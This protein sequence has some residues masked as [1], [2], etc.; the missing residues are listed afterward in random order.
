ML[1]N[2]CW[3][4][5]NL[6]SPDHKSHVAYPAAGPQTFTGSS[7]GGACPATHPVKIPQIMLEVSSFPV[8]RSCSLLLHPLFFHAPVFPNPEQN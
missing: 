6:D 8:P 5:K 7:V 3:D 4:G 1:A 2:S